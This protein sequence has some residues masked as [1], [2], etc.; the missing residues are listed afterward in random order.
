MGQSQYVHLENCKVIKGTDAAIHIEWDGAK[1][2]LPR[3]QI[4][5][6]DKYDTG[7][8]DVTISITEWVAEQKGIEV[9]E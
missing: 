3:S 8:R 9:E 5:N 4:A 7:D 6:G 1:Y 2:W